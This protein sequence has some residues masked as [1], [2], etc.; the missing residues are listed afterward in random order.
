MRLATSIGNK[1][2]M[3]RIDS[4]WSIRETERKG[5]QKLQ[6]CMSITGLDNGRPD[7]AELKTDRLDDWREGFGGQK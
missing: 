4:K 3:M 1:D 6:H 7:N 5:A 2:K